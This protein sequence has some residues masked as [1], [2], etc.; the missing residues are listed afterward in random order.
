MCKVLKVFKSNEFNFYKVRTFSLI[1]K[2]LVNLFWIG[3]E[4]ACNKLKLTLLL[5]KLKKKTLNDWY[6]L[7]VL[8]SNLNCLKF[9]DNFALKQLLKILSDCFYYSF[10]KNKI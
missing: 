5:I 1:S 8:I 9:C 2:L 10:T 6:F 4:K 3:I 7:Q